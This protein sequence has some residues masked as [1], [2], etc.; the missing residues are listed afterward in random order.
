MR[1]RRNRIRGDEEV[2]KRKTKRM[3]GEGKE[4]KLKRGR[5]R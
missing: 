5:G 1:E 2:G 4:R 3:T